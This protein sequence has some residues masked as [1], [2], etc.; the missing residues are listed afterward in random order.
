MDDKE[1]FER[2]DERNNAYIQFLTD[3]NDDRKK[4]TT[5]LFIIVFVLVG[6][7]IGLIACMVWISI[8]SQNKIEAMSDKSE[9][10]MYEFLS[11]YDFD[12]SYNLDTG[13]IVNSDTSG[14]INFNQ[15]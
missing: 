8:H 4:N 7:I 11:E 10:R 2:M 6:V 1:L 3:V 12:T 9:K 15:R 14:N 13:T 5:F